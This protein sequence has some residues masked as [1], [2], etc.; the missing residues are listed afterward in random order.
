M[1]SRRGRERK[2]TILEERSESSKVYICIYI[3]IHIYILPR[4][5]ERGEGSFRKK[6]RKK[7]KERKVEAFAKRRETERMANSL[8]RKSMRISRGNGNHL[9]TQRHVER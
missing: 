7:K 1:K 3:Y 4:K 5:I 8:S 9:E 6:G 2:N